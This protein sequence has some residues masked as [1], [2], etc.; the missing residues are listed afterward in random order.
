MDRVPP[1]LH[2]FFEQLPVV[3]TPE[4]VTPRLRALVKAGFPYLICLVSATAVE[5]LHLLAERV[6]PSVLAD[7][8]P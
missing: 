5:T 7:S 4:E 6:V 2:A 3:G 8:V 1:F